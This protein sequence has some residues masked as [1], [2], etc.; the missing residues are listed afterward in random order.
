[1][2]QMQEREKMF[3]LFIGIY[4]VL[5]F[6]KIWVVMVEIAWFVPYTTF[7]KTD[8]ALSHVGIV[9]NS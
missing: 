4:Q 8:L 7:W 9:I 5:K 1:M 3:F 2:N 6:G